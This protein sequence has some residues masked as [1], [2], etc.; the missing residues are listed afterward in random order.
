MLLDVKT[1]DTISSLTEFQLILV[2][3][4]AIIIKKL[5]QFCQIAI[6]INDC[7]LALWNTK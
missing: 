6:W 7:L 4:L 5:H 2:M 3:L 1:L